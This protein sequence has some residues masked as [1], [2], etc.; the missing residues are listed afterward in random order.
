[1]FVKLS[2][3]LEGHASRMIASHEGRKMLG[4]AFQ[5]SSTEISDHRLFGK[6]PDGSKVTD[7]VGHANDGLGCAPMPAVVFD[8]CYS[9]I[10]LL[11]FGD[12][13][14]ALL[15]RY[16]QHILS[17]LRYVYGDVTQS[18]STEPVDLAPSEL[19][20]YEASAIVIARL[21]ST[22]DKVRDGGDKTSVR[23]MSPLIARAIYRGLVTQSARLDGGGGE[24]SAAVSPALM[25]QIVVLSGEQRMWAFPGRGPRL[26]IRHLVFAM[27]IAL[28]GPWFCGNH[29]SYGYGLVQR[30]APSA[31]AQ[32]EQ[33]A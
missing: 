4:Y 6:N 20:T 29:R 14:V 31:A 19:Q 5:T 7:L 16:S 8:S 13:G 23:G 27:P 24:M 17:A 21:N 3:R 2:Y 9:G 15:L 30:W 26:I 11:G 18:I 1:M 10:T 33:A 32:R 22:I 25:D 12:D 28:T